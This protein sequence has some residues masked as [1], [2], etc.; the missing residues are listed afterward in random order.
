MKTTHAISGLSA[1]VS[2]ALS[3]GTVSAEDVLQTETV[4]VTASRVEQ[5]LME[6]PM[7][8]SVIT[9]KD[10]EKSGAKTVGDLLSDIP[11]VEIKNDGGQGIDR[12][13]IRGEDAFRTLVM[14]DGQKV[15][16]HKSMSGAPS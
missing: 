11:G 1:A 9:S 14:I 8:V 4:H 13:K 5:E 16:E 2:L 7:S 10:I 15:A 6:V 3:A 12:V